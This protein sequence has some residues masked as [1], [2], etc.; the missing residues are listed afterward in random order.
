MSNG[1]FVVSGFEKMY[2]DVIWQHYIFTNS[3]TGLCHFTD[4]KLSALFYAVRY[5][6]ASLVYV[7]NVSFVHE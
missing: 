5:V 6:M 2:F 4:N 1:V 7:K 3:D